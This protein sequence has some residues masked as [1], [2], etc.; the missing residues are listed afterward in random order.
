M[1]KYRC[2]F[3][4]RKFDKINGVVKHLRYC[5]YNTFIMNVANNV[6]SACGKQ[7][8]TWRALINHVS[9]E[10]LKPN[11]DLKHILLAYILLSYGSNVKKRSRKIVRRFLKGELNVEKKDEEEKIIYFKLEQEGDA[12]RLIA[13]DKDG[14]KLDD[15]NILSIDPREGSIYVFDYIAN[16]IGLKKV[17]V[18]NDMKV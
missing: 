13:V 4:G 10:S 1:G 14:E 8:R 3:C 18:P 6:C 15:G 5:Y 2:P 12:V 9:K 17:R 16:E 7:F 11:A